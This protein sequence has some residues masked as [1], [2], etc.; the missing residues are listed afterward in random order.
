[1]SLKYCEF[2]I[3][4]VTIVLGVVY[5]LVKDIESNIL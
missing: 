2:V 1:M 5:T 3:Y 4:I